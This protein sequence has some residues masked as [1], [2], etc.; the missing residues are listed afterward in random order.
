VDGAIS[1]WW[2]TSI[3]FLSGGLPTLTVED[4]DVA[5]DEVFE[6]ASSVLGEPTPELE[7]VDVDPE[8][9]SNDVIENEE[10]SPEPELDGDKGVALGLGRGETAYD[11]DIEA[12]GTV[13]AGRGGGGS[14][15]FRSNQT[16]LC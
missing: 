9:P 2:Y 8:S 15:C 12:N 14:C 5:V 1:V 16:H 6:A 7:P 3:I 13:S 11:D 10:S 4:T